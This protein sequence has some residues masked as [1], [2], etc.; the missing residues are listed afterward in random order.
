MQFFKRCGW[1]IDYIAIYNQGTHTRTCFVC[2]NPNGN[3]EDYPYAGEPTPA[4]VDADDEN[5]D[6]N[7]GP[8]K[9]RIVEKYT[10]SKTP[11][12]SEDMRQL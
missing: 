1:V 11:D 12:V 10:R 4:E 3:L 2:N 6:P 8:N 5:I 9:V 7:V